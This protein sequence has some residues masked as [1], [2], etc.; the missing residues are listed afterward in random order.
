M[1][2]WISKYIKDE[3]NKLFFN[4]DTPLDLID[5]EMFYREFE[6]ICTNLIYEKVY[7]DFSYFSSKPLLDIKLGQNNF[8]PVVIISYKNKL[9]LW[10]NKPACNRRGYF[11]YREYTLGIENKDNIPYLCERKHNLTITNWNRI[12]ED[13]GIGHN[14]G[15][16]YNSSNS[17]SV[18][19]DLFEVYKLQYNIDLTLQDNKLTKNNPNWLPYKL[20]LLSD[21]SMQKAIEED[22]PKAFVDNE[23]LFN[24]NEKMT[25]YTP[26]LIMV[27]SIKRV[28][29]NLTQIST[30]CNSSGNTRFLS[31]KYTHPDNQVYLGKGKAISIVNSQYQRNLSK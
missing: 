23:I 15:T 27:T 30:I 28:N 29:P 31:K 5:H 4:E 13:Y 19:N 16:F 26:Y 25:K 22:I 2:N 18:F 20:P 14:Q 24:K 10:I 8:S 1:S 12:N 3:Y 7:T 11:G 6:K 21:I 9:P 17:I